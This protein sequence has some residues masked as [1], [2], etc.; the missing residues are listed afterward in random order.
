MPDSDGIYG[1]NEQLGIG[2]WGERFLDAFYHERFII[3]SVT[4]EQQRQGLDRIYVGRETG[5]RFSVE[6]K[7]DFTAGRTGNAFIETTS[8][9]ATGTK[10]WAFTSTA[11]V[12]LYFV[13]PDGTIYALDMLRIKIDA[14]KL[15]EEFP[16]KS[17]GNKGYETEGVV[18]SLGV[19]CDRYKLW[20]SLCK[21]VIPSEMNDD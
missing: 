3:E 14:E 5:K 18:V 19:I 11:Q 1:F 2:K 13:P 17:A 8:V 20:Q 9:S 4:M 21:R 10:G 15:I 16:L 7:T 12:L 6:Y